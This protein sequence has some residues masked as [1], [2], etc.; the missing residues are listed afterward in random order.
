MDKIGFKILLLNLLLYSQVVNFVAQSWVNGATFDY[1]KSSFQWETNK[2]YN[3][4]ITFPN[5]S[6][7]KTFEAQLKSLS[8]K[9]IQLGIKNHFIFKRNLLVTDI[10][11]GFNRYQYD[12]EI[13]KKENSTFL[14]T[15]LNES[16][17]SDSY[18]WKRFALNN[19]YSFQSVLPK[20]RF[21]LGY[22]REVFNYHNLAFYADAGVLIDKQF[23]SFQKLNHDIYTQ[24][25]TIS[26]PF[27]LLL[28]NRKILTSGYL[29]FTIRYSSSSI[30]FKLGRQF[31]SNFITESPIQ[32][33]QN[34]VQV[35]YS[36][37]FKEVHLGKEQVIYDE[38]Q[39][40]TQ[41][42]A[43]EY[44]KGDKLS[45]ADFGFSHEE[46]A[47]YPHDE[48]NKELVVE[49]TDTTFVYTQGY[50][51]KPE[52]NLRLGVNSY[53]TNRWLM[54]LS[55]SMYKETY[56][57]YGYVSDGISSS[58]YGNNSNDQYET[59]ASKTK[60]SIGINSAIYLTKE[61]FMINPFIRGGA[62]MVM[63]YDVPS[64]LKQNSEWR[65]V[66]FFP[67]YS[68][69]A[70]VDLRLRLRSSK[71]LVLGIGFDKVLNPHIDYNKIYV[72]VGYYR[73]KK[74]KNQRY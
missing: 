34:F 72:R 1:A 14:D 67:Y 23:T 45:Y 41:T 29:G 69:G 66:A 53:F 25:D 64:F 46:E 32:A 43:S 35:S 55:V 33:N 24:E 61:A 73:K 42:R 47:I 51:V 7:N 65:T 20:I 26:V 22:K 63:D 71:F 38:F 59:S 60:Y 44:R 5:L 52:T 13:S 19:T 9:S 40:L 62:N 31:G 12:F 28:K 15:S 39:H 36:K 50:K 74:L 57:T 8:N 6:Y 3:V 10:S 48:V 70:G 2:S 16:G 18:L 21:N 54:G 11:L 49:N 68:Y 27:G 58:E 56:H 37:L 4:P 17:V 30:A